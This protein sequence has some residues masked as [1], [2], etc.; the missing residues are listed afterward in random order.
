MRNF[1]HGL[2]TG[3]M[4]LTTLMVPAA[5][6]N[7]SAEGGQVSGYK[8]S[9]Y[10]KPSFTT[11][12]KNLYSNFSVLVSENGMS[13][14]T[15]NNGYFEIANVAPSQSGFTLKISK[16]GYLSRT[17][18]NIPG[19]QGN[20]N[21]GSANSPVS[22][23]AGD[24]TQ[25]DTINMSDVIKIANS[26]NAVTN[27]AKY[28]VSTDINVNGSINMEDVIILATAFGS[29]SNSYSTVTP[30]IIPTTI[31]SST[32]ITKPTPTPTTSVD[33][34]DAW[35]LNTGTI[36][37]GSTITYTGTGISVSGSTVKITA[38]GDH[39]VSGTLTNGMILV[40][41]TERVKL[42]LSNAS[43]TNSSGPAIYGKN[44]D[45]L[46]ITLDKDTINTLAD[47][48]TYSDSTLKAA[49]FS[50]DDLE[51]KGSGTLNITGNYNHAIAS[52][53]DVIIEN[54]IINVKSSVSDG[55]HANGQVHVKGGTLNITSTKDCLQCE[56]EDLLID[57][58][59]LTLSAGSQGLNSYVSVTINGGNINIT[60]SREGIES[61]LININ[62]GTI[63]IIATDDATNSSMGKR[64]E[65]ND[66]SQTIITGGSL[67]ASSASGDSVDSNGSI[68]IKGGTVVVSGPQSS[69]NVPLDCNGP[70][71]VTGGTLL[72]TGPAM[73][74]A[75]YPNGASA[76]YSIAVG[77]SSSQSANSAVCIKDSTGKILLM[78]KPI[79][80]YINIVFSSPE[81]KN[82]STY[83]VSYGGTVSGGTTVNGVITGGTY[84][85]GTS[86]NVTIN[87]SPTTT[88]NWSS[89]GFPW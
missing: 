84:S 40:D 36:N 13:A 53:D 69:P 83:T 12:N 74:M 44:A 71:T 64:T 79:R 62:G 38:G 15:D 20:I 87:K 65:T 41:T 29:T 85:G 30:T 89:G 49:L 16:S 5:V 70:L 66:G 11:T 39:T 60:K 19:Q 72:A 43:I 82:G 8:I 42:R 4:V 46:F 34:S 56:T 50:N 55:I 88:V 63:S 26:F 25:D 6:L 80:N 75:Q 10:V 78:T 86:T 9:G 37:L 27:D 48:R 31:T 58:G 23:I 73:M 35:Q 28:S 68:T 3:A 17:F 81:L 14:T 7:V 18:S 47:G 24:I 33:P 2:I 51:I 52:D 1:L 54:G 76:Q 22:I 77:L 67:Y 61:K 45:K 32:P 21:F 57:D 59:A